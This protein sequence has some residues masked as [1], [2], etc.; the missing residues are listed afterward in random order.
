MHRGDAPYGYGLTGITDPAYVLADE[1]MVLVLHHV[2]DT[3]N[4]MR[5][6]FPHSLLVSV[7]LGVGAS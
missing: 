6:A 4:G 1:L 2:V 5:S 3:F 7:C